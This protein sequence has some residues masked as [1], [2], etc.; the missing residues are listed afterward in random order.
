MRFLFPWFS[1]LSLAFSWRLYEEPIQILEPNQNGVYEIDL[2]IEH[3]I[4]MTRKKGKH[5]IQ[6]VDYD[7][8]SSQWTIRDADVETACNASSVLM[9]K[10]TSEMKYIEELDSMVQ[11]TGQHVK[12]VTIN[13][14]TP[15]P[16]IAVPHG[17]EV[18]LRVIN[19]LE[20]DKRYLWYTDGVAFVQQCPI[21]SGSSY[22]Y[23]FIADTPGTHWYHGHL[24]NDRADGMLGGFVIYPKDQTTPL[25][26][27]DRIRTER[28]Y[29]M[30]IQDWATLPSDEQWLCHIHKTMKW[31]GFG[32]DDEARE[33][34]WAPKRTYDG[35]N[36]G[37]SIPLA[38]ILINS[39]GWYN[40]DD[41]RQRPKTLPLTTYRI[42]TQE[43]Q[44]YRIVNGGVSQGIVVW[45]EGHQM[46]VVAADGVEVK[47]MV[48]DAVIVFPG[49]RYDVHIQGLS[50]PTQKVYRFILETMDWDWTVG[51]PQLGLANLVYEDVDLPDDGE[52]DFAH[53]KCTTN[54]KCKLLNCPFLDFPSQLNWTCI[55]A[56]KLENAE[57]LVDGEILEQKMFR[58]DFKEVFA[59]MNYDNHID[60]YM[61]KSPRGMPYY[62]Q[63][64]LEEVA[65]LCDPFKC[66]RFHSDRWDHNCDC[67][68]HYTFELGDIV[69]M[70]IYN[71]GDGGRLGN[72]YSHPIHIHGTHFYVMKIGY[73]QY[74]P[75]NMTIKA[76]N[77]DIPC[78]DTTKKCVDLQWSDPS[79]A[80]GNVPEM[81]H[82]PSFRDTINLP[83][84]GYVT[85]RF[86]ATNPGW[87]YAHCH[88]MLH[89]MGG[90]AFSFRVGSPEQI[91]APP[92]NFPYSCGI[93][94]H[95]LPDDESYANE[96][97]SSLI[98]VLVCI[99]YSFINIAE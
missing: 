35:S 19:E 96:R 77:L 55:S 80:R 20:I 72:G 54:S 90:T 67:F 12:I 44:R 95:E 22:T 63:D 85:L 30:I 78:F 21:S 88:L 28:E 79:W 94:R 62:H 41:I 11:H 34:C 26:T 8:M 64:N 3:K 6:V 1:L 57:P 50:K 74:F 24:M 5:E 36:V 18:L 93:Y 99:L 60:G 42:R 92:P 2:V 31:V 66:D 61:F 40:R 39:K 13:G 86:R 70:T 81:E 84:G 91:P 10:E 89:H 33:K 9:G 25:V 51:K 49:E 75:E 87:W 76:M 82:N 15:G 97:T 47:P 98:L 52:I 43:H 29:Y 38:A 27:G 56:H 48:V 68:Y 32:F 69:Q 14:K 58:D 16:N 53:V 37:G 46:T 7:P 45:C 83:T 59:N 73:P 17:A 65:T 23:R 4:S 71:M